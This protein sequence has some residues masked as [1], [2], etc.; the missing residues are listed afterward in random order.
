MTNCKKDC[1]VLRIILILCLIL[2]HLTS[3]AQEL[4]VK[5]T[6]NHQQVG[7]TTRTDIFE[8]LQEKM[9]NFLNEKT[10]TTMHF[11]ENERIECS[12][13]LVVNTYSN[14]DNTFKC[15]LLLTAS[16]PV[17]DSS[18]T[19]ATYSVNDKH[20]DFTFQPTDQLEFA[21]SDRLDN[22]LVAL[23]A[24][25][26]YMVIGYDMDSMSPLGG[27]PYFQIAEDIVTNAESL[28]YPGWK[29]FDDN[30][31][32][33]ALLNDLM[34]GAMEP[35]RQLI[36][37][38]HR[39]GLDHMTEDTEAARTAITEAI[40]LLDEAHQAKSM[41][42]LPQIFTEYKRDE[43]VNIYQGKGKREEREA[44]YKVLFDIDP[45]QSDNWDKIKN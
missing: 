3:E 22:N 29:A 12:M 25:Y 37:K 39:E 15:N 32:R 45:S 5:L 40:T 14:T 6:I 38:Y 19:T 17:F 1:K 26:A 44:V 31:N 16:R 2:G 33:F 11:R 36:Y 28:G 13:T 7:N 41:S 42:L 34:D 9:T 18:Y 24:Y 8:A 27:T 4:Q 21:G 23:L 20:F 35:Y 10:W 43:L 30:R